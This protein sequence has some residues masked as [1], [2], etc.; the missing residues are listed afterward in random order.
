MS[1]ERIASL[2][3]TVEQVSTFLSYHHA[4]NAWVNADHSRKDRCICH[5]QMLDAFDTQLGINDGHWMVSC[6]H[7]T[8]AS[9]MID[10]VGGAPCIFSKL[11]LILDVTAGSELSFDPALKRG[12]LSNFSGQ[13]HSCEEKRFIIVL[14][15]GKVTEVNQRSIFWIGRA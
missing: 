6:S 12:L 14:L 2:L 13:L 9:G 3:S 7:T 10:R 1:C 8:G 11:T 4:G 5:S 15:I